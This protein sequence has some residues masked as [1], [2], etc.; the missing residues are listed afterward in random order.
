M[1]IQGQ[2]RAFREAVSMRYK[3]E[4]GPDR[5]LMGWMVQHS[6]WVVHNFQVRAHG[7][8]PY[9]SLRGRDYIGEVV[10]LGEVC[11]GRNHPEVGAKLNMRWMRGAFVGKLDRTDEF[12]LITPTGAM[13]TRCVR[14]LESVCWQSVTAGTNNPTKG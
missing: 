12:L 7:G 10:P 11:F 3:T 2:L 14:R 4:I 5:V 9:R 1:T 13:E 6:A 8:T